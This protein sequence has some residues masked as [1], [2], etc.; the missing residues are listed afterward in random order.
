MSDL[1]KEAEKIVD[2]EK[3]TKEDFD[4]FEDLKYTASNVQENLLADDLLLGE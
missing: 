1:I 4:R 3:L 2:K